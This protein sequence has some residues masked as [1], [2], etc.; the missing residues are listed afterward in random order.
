MLAECFYRAGD[1]NWHAAH[2]YTCKILSR[3]RLCE[4][5]LLSIRHY[6]G[7]GFASAKAVEYE[8]QGAAQDAFY[9]QHFIS[10]VYEGFER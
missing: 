9:L 3:I 7:K 5:F 4:T 8:G 2:V 1:M 10:S 6:L